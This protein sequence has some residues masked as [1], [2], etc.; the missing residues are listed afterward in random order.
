M[1]LTP[2]R[3]SKEQANEF[4]NRLH[5]HHDSDQGHRFSIGCWNLKADALC[6]VAVVGEP[7]APALGRLRRLVEVTR[8]CTDGTRQACSWLYAAAAEHAR[9]DGWAGIITYTLSSEGG[10]SLRGAGW[11]GEKL[12]KSS[13]SWANRAGRDA[14]HVRA[15]MRWFKALNN[16]WREL[17]G[18]VADVRQ[19]E[20]FS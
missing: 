19:L 9:L 11:W 15:D 7:R 5:R 6:G 17:P 4:V 16:D 18:V 2:I 1:S 14:D 12:P 8:L 13:A 10:A 3:V 20:A